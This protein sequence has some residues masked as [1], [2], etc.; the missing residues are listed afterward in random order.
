V[1]AGG[2]LDWDGDGG[3]RTRKRCLGSNRLRVGWGESGQLP[4]LHLLAHLTFL[5]F[6]QLIQAISEYI[7]PPKPQQSL[8][9]NKHPIKILYKLI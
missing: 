3:G 7:F 4:L 2:A 8:I 5:A 6:L 9:K 1:V